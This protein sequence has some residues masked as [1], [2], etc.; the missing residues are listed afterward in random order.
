MKI[1]DEAG[2]ILTIYGTF[3]ADGTNRYDSMDVKPIAG[4]TVKVYGIIGQYNGTAQMKN[5][6][7][8]EHVP[9]EG[10]GEVEPP[11]VEP[12]VENTDPTPDTELTIAEAIVLG[13]S[14]DHDTYTEG[15]YYVTGEITE[16]YNTQY[17]NM[18]I[19]DEAGNILTIYGTYD[20]DGTNR[21]D[22]MDVKP[23]A[24]DTVKV[25]GI[26]GQYYGTAQMKNGW[27]VEHVPGE[28]GGEVEP[29]VV[30][31]EPTVNYVA[32]YTAEDDGKVMT[33]EPSVYNNKDQM[34]TAAAALA[35][36]KVT[37]DAEN[38]ALFEVITDE[39]GI[40]A[41]K[42]A[43]G[44]FLYADGTHVRI[45][46]EEGECTKFVLEGSFIRCATAN[47]NGKAQYLE[48]Y[49]QIITCYGMN[50]SK[51]NIYTFQLLPV[52][53]GGSTE[54]PNPE[55]EKP[56]LTTPQEIIDAAYALGKGETLGEYPLT[57]EITEVNTPYSEQY[58]NVTVTIAVDGT[59]GKT[60]ECFRLKGEGAENLKVGDKI[61]VTGTIKNYA[62]SSE[63]GKVEFDAGCTFVLADDGETN[64]PGSSLKETAFED[65]KAGDQVLIVVHASYTDKDYVLLNNADKGVAAAFDGA[66]YDDTMTWVVGG[67]AA[68]GYTFYVGE[69]WLYAKNINNGVFTGTEATGSVWT[70]QA[71]GSYSWL[72]ATDSDGD[73]RY[74]GVWDNNS[75]KDLDEGQV[76]NFRVYENYTNNTK[77]QTTK[78]YVVGTAAVPEVKPET[79][80]EPEKP[81]LTT[82]Q[83]IIDAAYALGKGETL[84]EYPL[85]GEI[86]EVN[87]PYSEQYKNVTVT[88]AVDGTDGKTIECFRLK[89]EGAENLKVGDKITVTGT[90]KNY[91]DSS[92]TGKVEFDAGCTFTL[93][94]A[95]SVEALAE[96]A[97]TNCV[98]AAI[99]E[100]STEEIAA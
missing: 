13:A 52:A 27:I 36:G 17:G 30:E 18:K 68:T 25:Y 24:G 16:V 96:N 56:V 42:T 55:P 90:I 84:G 19:T 40:T 89:G 63:T 100:E 86:T 31:P 54:T 9:G 29:P 94:A 20:A 59:D 15:K 97:A 76:I 39:D 70:L 57:G 35:D 53:E 66:T 8:V 61:T 85:T 83:E 32:I 43:D 51:E 28:G 12:P 79:P 88:I 92:E 75:G 41:F 93:A 33:T 74:M 6:W 37:T 77:N 91:A 64:V 21:Y 60:I 67:E 99:V 87:T 82:P 23:V 73:V 62:D 10:G 48:Y 71:D 98:A 26:I 45:V 65:L 72:K 47:Y 11:V 50:A 38:V 2:N 3:D 69:K 14:K 80:V 81:V 49:N 22:A 34:K 7:I 58:K 5:G 78:F 95:A 1:T 46:D 4:D 44:K